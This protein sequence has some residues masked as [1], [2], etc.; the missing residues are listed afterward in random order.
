MPLQMIFEWSWCSGEVPADQKLANVPIFKEGKKENP[1][2]YRPVSLPLVPSKI[3]EKVI[4]GGTEKYMGDNAVI[5][6]ILH[7]HEEKILLIEPDFLLPQSNPP[8]WS[9]KAS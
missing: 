2:N 4:L 9:R 8:S 5:G 1:G 6:N 3:T 7:G